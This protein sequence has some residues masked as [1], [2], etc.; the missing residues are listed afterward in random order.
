MTARPLAGKPRRDARG[1]PSVPTGPTASV[2]FFKKVQ[3]AGV[4]PAGAVYQA[5]H[6][7]QVTGTF[8]ACAICSEIPGPAAG[9]CPWRASPH[10]PQHSFLIRQQ[11]IISSC[12][13]CLR[14][15]D[16]GKN[17][18]NSSASLQQP[19]ELTASSSASAAGGSDKAGELSSISGALGQKNFLN[20]NSFGVRRQC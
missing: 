16:W 2:I 8:L 14:N 1:I 12:Y 7:R 15:S 3:Q 17:R 18:C 13:L 5:C 20:P 6:M 11:Q 10:H 9:P 19:A 4:E